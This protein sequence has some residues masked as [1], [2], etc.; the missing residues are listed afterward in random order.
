MPGMGQ[1]QIHL[2]QLCGFFEIFTLTPTVAMSA[3]GVTF[4]R[5]LDFANDHITNTT[6]Q[7]MAC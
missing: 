2:A 3:S 1:N 5:A 4:A 6:H 7:R